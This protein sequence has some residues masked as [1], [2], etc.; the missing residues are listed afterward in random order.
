MASDLPCLQLWGSASSSPIHRWPSSV[1]PSASSSGCLTDHQGH[2]LLLLL[3][4][5][6]LPYH[7]A[8]QPS[9]RSPFLQVQLRGLEL[10][11]MG[12]RSVARILS[13]LLPHWPVRKSDWHCLARYR[14][15]VGMRRPPPDN[16]P[17]S[18]VRDW[19]KPKVVSVRLG[20]SLIIRLTPSDGMPSHM[21]DQ[22]QSPFLRHRWPTSDL[23]C[24]SE[25][26]HGW[27]SRPG[28]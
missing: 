13:F 26:Q 10:L 4:G 19:Q 20:I 25:L 17:E 14:D 8:C 1:E 28:S 7:E 27:N 24:S 2:P 16:L 18:S 11:W 23:L 15:R 3:L 12:Y 6:H 22:P 5:H 9:R 21:M